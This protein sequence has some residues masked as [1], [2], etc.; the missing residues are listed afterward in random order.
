MFGLRIPRGAKPTSPEM[1]ILLSELQ[2]A[3]ATTSERQAGHWIGVHSALWRKLLGRGYA[4][5]IR[6]AQRLGFVEVNNRYSVGHFSKSYRLAKR[7]RVP[8]TATFDLGR[9]LRREC[10]QRIR[11]EDGD[12][13]GQNLAGC[14]GAVGIPDGLKISGWTRYTV[15]GI[16]SQRWYATRCEYGRL[17]TTFTGLPK[18]IRQLLTVDG[19]PAVEVDVSNCQPL[20]VGILATNQQTT[21]NQH[22]TI[23]THK[24]KTTNHM[25]CSDSQKF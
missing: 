24:Q 18:S 20:I 2:A 17:H 12:V 22:T 8:E 14:F 9:R 23:N 25:W 6:E 13:V 21:P 3:H 7:Y 15:E 1:A 5:V 19:R 4:S 11:I 10:G 16:R